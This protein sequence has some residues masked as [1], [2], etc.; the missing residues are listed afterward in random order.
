MRVAAAHPQ[1]ALQTNLLG[2]LIARRSPA[3][4]KRSVLAALSGHVTDKEREEIKRFSRRTP[5]G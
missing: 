5:M 4:G 1:N 3:P 2:D